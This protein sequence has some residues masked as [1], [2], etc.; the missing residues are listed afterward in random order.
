M[1][2][3]DYSI[4]ETFRFDKADNWESQTDLE[5]KFKSLKA[6]VDVTFLKVWIMIM[7]IAAEMNY[8]F[9]NLFI[10]KVGSSENISKFCKSDKKPIF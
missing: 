7:M 9:K 6:S 3:K 5:K 2:E 8:I 10:K 1:T 4:I